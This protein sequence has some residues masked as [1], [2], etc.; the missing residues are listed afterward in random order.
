MINIAVEKLILIVK[1]AFMQHG[2]SEISAQSVANALVRAQMDGQNGHGLSRIDSY[3]AQLQTGKIKGAAIPAYEFPRPAIC[4]V[5]AKF[6][7]AYP[8]MDILIEQLPAL[9]KTYGIAFGAVK[10]SHHFGQAGYHVERLADQGL[11]ALAFS[12]TPKAMA[13]WGGRDALFGTNPIAMACPNFNEVDGESEAPLVIDMSLS[14][15]ARGKIMAASKQDKQ[16]PEG[17]ARDQD[18]NPTTDPQLALKGTMEP[19]GGAKG[20]ALALMVEILS[21][22]LTGGNF[23]F[24][25]SSFFEAEGESPAIGHSVIVIDPL[26]TTGNK[27]AGAGFAARM[28]YLF[29]TMLEQEG[30]RLPGSSRISKRQTHHQ[31][32]IEIDP[33][34]YKKYS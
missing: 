23:S 32:G 16:I 14:V 20:G 30:V 1:N 26:A 29:R 10:N 19:M 5:D 33:A 15:A 27:D 9:A 18:G 21:A 8:A 24:E 7:F 11:I 12:N 3:L 17:W 4:A 25:A 22:G 6:G 28:A 31:N 34:F 13:P 2:A